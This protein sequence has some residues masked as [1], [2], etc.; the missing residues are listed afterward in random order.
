MALFYLE[1]QIPEAQI[2][3]TAG[4]LDSKKKQGLRHMPSRRKPAP[5][6][7]RAKRRPS[8]A[9]LRRQPRAHLLIIECDSQKLAADGLNLGS[10]FWQLVRTLFP[11]KKIAIVRTSSEKRLNEDLGAVFGQ[12]GRIR[13]VLILGHSNETGLALTADGLRSWE[14]VGNWLQRFGPEFCFLAAC[15]AGKS[16]AV[17]GLFKP[18]PT[19]RQVYASPAVLHKNQLPPLALL[20]LMLLKDGRIDEDQSGALRLVN[21]VLTGGQLFRW[22]RAEAGPAEEVKARMLDA[23]SSILDQGSWDLLERLFPST[24]QP[25]YAGWPSRSAQPT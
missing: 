22:R 3:T 9:A 15:K 5:K 1:A 8:G 4:L 11:D 2:P 14:V 17:R 12:Y 18:V 25:H 13:S 23:I 16:E 6:S 10:P 24:G 21:Y 7:I 20:I 19:L